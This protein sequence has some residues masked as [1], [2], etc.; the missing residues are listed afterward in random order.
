[1]ICSQ[2]VDVSESKTCTALLLRHCGS[3]MRATRLV[4]SMTHTRAMIAEYDGDGEC[5]AARV[6]ETVVCAMAF[7]CTA[8]GHVSVSGY[9]RYS[10]VPSAVG[11]AQYVTNRTTHETVTV[12]MRA[13]RAA[14]DRAEAFASAP[15]CSLHGVPSAPALIPSKSP[16]S[17][18]LSHDEPAIE[19]VP[20]SGGWP[21]LEARS[22]DDS[23]A[24]GKWVSRRLVQLALDEKVLQDATKAPQSEAAVDLASWSV[25]DVSEWLRTTVRFDEQQV[26][27]LRAQGI[28]GAELTT[29]DD[30]DLRVLGVAE[31]QQRKHILRQLNILR[32]RAPREA[33]SGTLAQQKLA[34]LLEAKRRRLHVLGECTA[35]VLATTPAIPLRTRRLLTQLWQQAE[36]VSLDALAQIEC[37]DAARR[38]REAEQ[39]ER[40]RR[41]CRRRLEAQMRACAEAEDALHEAREQVRVEQSKLQALREAMSDERG[42]RSGKSIE[43]TPERAFSHELVSLLVPSDFSIHEISPPE[44]GDS[45]ARVSTDLEALV[46]TAEREG[47]HADILLQTAEA[48]SREMESE[49]SQHAQREQRLRSLSASREHALERERQRAKAEAEAAAA[50]AAEAAALAALAPMPAAASSKKPRRAST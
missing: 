24:V 38:Q 4:T 35:K 46:A 45:F 1:M 39:A 27:A 16:S 15:A 11:S 13:L 30:L 21:T 22:R 26:E 48:V 49:S 19:A 41:A 33:A 43:M 20:S 23:A 18:I 44:L 10:S 32:A 40:A 34:R 25:D 2:S 8:G 17:A 5:A 50:V 37:D 42:L 12:P 6:L 3:P 29:L 9:T 36:G 7:V 31:L 14:L 28:S 47:Y